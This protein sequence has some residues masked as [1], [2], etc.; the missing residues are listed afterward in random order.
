MQKNEVFIL[1][2]SHKYLILVRSTGIEDVR[3]LM[4]VFIFKAFLLLNA[5]VDAKNFQENYINIL[6][7]IVFFSAIF[8]A[9]TNR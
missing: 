7:F 4:K 1:P 6:I 2:N 9:L 8:Y 3:H 5:K